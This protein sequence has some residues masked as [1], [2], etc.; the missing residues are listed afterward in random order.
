MKRLL[1]IVTFTLTTT[2]LFAQLDIA[3]RSWFFG[4]SLQQQPKVI[5]VLLDS[6][7]RILNIPK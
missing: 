4:V 1:S 7:A 5:Q 3:E 2:Q 6:D